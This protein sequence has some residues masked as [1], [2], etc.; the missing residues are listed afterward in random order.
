MVLGTVWYSDIRKNSDIDTVFIS[1]LNRYC[2]YMMLLR[3]CQDFI[4]FRV[5]LNLISDQCITLVSSLL[6]SIET[7]RSMGASGFEF[8]FHRASNDLSKIIP[9]LGLAANNLIIRQ[10]IT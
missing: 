3:V 2:Y 8:Y 5:F 7:Q 10:Q 9:W 6:P 1:F 4:S